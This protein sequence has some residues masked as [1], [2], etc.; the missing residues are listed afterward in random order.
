[1]D[2]KKILEAMGEASDKD[3]DRHV[4]RKTLIGLIASADENLA[5]HHAA[6]RYGA[7]QILDWALGQVDIDNVEG[8][9]EI[10]EAVKRVKE[11]VIQHLDP[12]GTDRPPC[13]SWWWQMKPL[14]G[15]TDE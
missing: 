6:I 2:M 9:Q 5:S 4:R 8:C 7:L 15:H 13:I 1:M 10:A 14:K 12:Q 3:K 11:L